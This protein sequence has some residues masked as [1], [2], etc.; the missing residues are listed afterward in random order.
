MRADHAG[1]ERLV[2][3]KNEELGF[4]WRS[5][6]WKAAE[7]PDG[8]LEIVISRREL[9]EAV[10]RTLEAGPADGPVLELPGDRIRMRVCGKG[11]CCELWAVASVV[12]L[13]REPEHSSELLTQELMGAG[14]R[15]LDALGDWYFVM[16]DDGYHGWVRSWHVAVDAAGEAERYR[17]RTDVML[18][19]GVDYILSEPDPESLPVSDVTAGTELVSLDKANGYVR[20][21]LPG[22]RTG[23][24]PGRSLEGSRDRSPSREGVVERARRLIGIPYVWG[25]TSA[26]GFDCSGLVRRVFGMEGMSVPRDADQ[27]AAAARTISEEPPDVPP[28][29]L[30]F[31][32]EDEDHVTHVAISSG[33]GR[34][35]HAYGEVRI[36]SLDGADPLFEEK[37]AEK[38][39]RAATFFRF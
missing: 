8:T 25:G 11:A 24:I 18:S 23:F 9:F 33:G 21:E 27:Q 19:A 35:V 14:M 10:A 31:F 1:I 22:G 37:L 26:K 39:L 5:S 13:R 16:L 30:L 29:D 12:D 17:A 4:D 34:F 3:D 36:N 38:Y 28:G 20:V 7:Q 6:W 32:G 15:V 2:S